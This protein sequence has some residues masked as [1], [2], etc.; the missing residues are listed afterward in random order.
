MLLIWH[1]S[2]AFAQSKALLFLSVQHA[3]VCPRVSVFLSTW[4]PFIKKSSNQFNVLKS[5]FLIIN[6]FCFECFPIKI[7]VFENRSVII[8]FI[9]KVLYF[10]TFPPK[11]NFTIWV[12]SLENHLLLASVNKYTVDCKSVDRMQN[13]QDF[14]K[15]QISKI[16]TQKCLSGDFE[17]FWFWA[18]T[19]H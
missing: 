3:Y 15:Y 19:P 18:L 2:C 11:F 10:L 12:S 5:I 8:N 4:F 9:Q 7:L 16:S 17:Q 6:W 14:E 13:V 1:F